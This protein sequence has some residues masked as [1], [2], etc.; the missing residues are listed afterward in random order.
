LSTKST[1]SCQINLSIVSNE[2]A[3]EAHNTSFGTLDSSYAKNNFDGEVV[4][5]LFMFELPQSLVKPN[6]IVE[7]TF[8][9]I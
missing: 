9:V 1:T 3:A 8:Y 4:N 5:N 2:L 7:A 6:I